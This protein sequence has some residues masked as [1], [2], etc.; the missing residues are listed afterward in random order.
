MERQLLEINGAF[1]AYVDDAERRSSD[2]L[3][4]EHDLEERLRSAESRLSETEQEK[5]DVEWRKRDVEDRLVQTERQKRD[6]EEQ[7]LNT[8]WRLRE[9]QKMSIVRFARFFSKSVPL[10]QRG[11]SRDTNRIA[12]RHSL[13][14]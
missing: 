2:A 11:S 5:Q 14:C 12:W 8:A 1:C 6:A 10:R 9:L 7:L 13:R 4:R 3:T